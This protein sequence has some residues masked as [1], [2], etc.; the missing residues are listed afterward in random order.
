MRPTP[1]IPIRGQVLQAHPDDMTQTSK[2][3]NTFQLRVRE[4]SHKKKGSEIGEREPL[5]YGDIVI[6]GEPYKTL[7]IPRSLFENVP[8]YRPGTFKE[9]QISLT[10]S[11]NTSILLYQ[12]IENSVR[13]S[14]VQIA[15]KDFPRKETRPRFDDRGVKLTPHEFNK[16]WRMQPRIIPI[17]KYLLGTSGHVKYCENISDK[18]FITVSSKHPLYPV[19]IREYI[20]TDEGRF[21]TTDGHRFTCEEWERFLSLGEFIPALVARLEQETAHILA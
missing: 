21:K 5:I 8:E 13:G 1:T 3:N 20:F 19:D 6:R 2:C 17:F 10:L 15:F 18:T 7:S 4:L 11:R 14:D 12:K 9:I 16:M